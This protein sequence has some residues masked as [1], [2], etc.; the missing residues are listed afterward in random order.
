MLDLHREERGDRHRN[1]ELRRGCQNVDLA[2][3]RHLSIGFST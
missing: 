1:A 2:P 3:G